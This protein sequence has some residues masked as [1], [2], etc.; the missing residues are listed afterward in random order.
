M[1]SGS[2]L[3]QLA[4][5][6]ACTACG[7]SKSATAPS[8]GTF[9]I[10]SVVANPVV[11]ECGLGPHATYVTAYI[12]HLVN[13]TANDVTVTGV[14]STGQIVRSTRPEEAGMAWNTFASL[15]FSPSLVAS[16]DFLDMGVT[17]T[18][19]CL[20]HPP[21][22]TD[23][24]RDVYTMLHVI[25]TSGVYATPQITTTI[26]YRPLPSSMRSPSR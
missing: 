26:I 1:R 17:L 11:A 7:G 2:R 13:T 16:H 5:I 14:S 20:P 6:A 24:F 21:I 9:Q 12:L 23:E 8:T 19:S 10:A 22:T 18:S 15:P 25:A 4:L 3:S